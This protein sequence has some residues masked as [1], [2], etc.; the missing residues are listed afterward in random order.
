MR[1]ENKK[2]LMAYLQPISETNMYAKSKCYMWDNV[3][4]SG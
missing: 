2:N 4:I 1:N 3:A